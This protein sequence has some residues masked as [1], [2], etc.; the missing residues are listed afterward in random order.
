MQLLSLD[1]PGTGLA[2]PDEQATHDAMLEAPGA[3]LY[4]PAGHASKVIEALI[5]P[6]L[7]QKPPTG[8]SLHAVAPGLSLKEPVEQGWQALWPW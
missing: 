5:A 4:V 2:L 3:L 7:A 1:L 6:T 8:Q